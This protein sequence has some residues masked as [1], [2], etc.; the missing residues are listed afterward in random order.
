MTEGTLRLAALIALVGCSECYMAPAVAAAPI[1]DADGGDAADAVSSACDPSQTPSIGDLPDDVSAVLR[2]KCQSCHS[3][4]PQHHA[5]FPLVSFEDT[6]KRFGITTKRRWQRMAEVIEPGGLPHMPY[7][8]APPLADT[9]LST[10]RLW[11]AG[12]ATPVPEGTGH[13]L[14]DDGGLPEH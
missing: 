12:C 3:A 2:D 9:Q 4:P 10:L 7:G 1:A 5:P 11:F 8:T 6:Q 14:T 13:D